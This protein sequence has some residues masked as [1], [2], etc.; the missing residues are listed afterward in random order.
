MHILQENFFTALIWHQICSLTGMK[1]IVQILGVFLFFVA[2]LSS[3]KF[4]ES[5]TSQYQQCA[6]GW[7][8]EVDKLQ[9]RPQLRASLIMK[10]DQGLLSVDGE[11]CPDLLPA[12]R[13]KIRAKIAA[14]Y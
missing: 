14:N 11:D 7:A 3:V 6:A 8:L 1:Q 2:T 4:L 13:Q 12:H 5:Y 9:S 10:L